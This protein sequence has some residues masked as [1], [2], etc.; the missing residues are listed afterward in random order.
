VNTIFKMA[1]V[2]QMM[3]GER[4]AVCVQCTAESN[5]GM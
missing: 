1:I 3:D 4:T 5:A 2:Q